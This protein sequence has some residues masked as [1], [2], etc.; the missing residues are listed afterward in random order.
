MYNESPVHAESCCGLTIKIFNDDCAVNPYEEWDRLGTLYHWHKR[1][2]IGESLSR[3]EGYE[4]KE[5]IKQIKQNGGVIVP[6]YLY[7]HGGQT[8]NTSGF[9]CPWD[10]G[11]VGFWAVTREEILKEYGKKRVSKAMREK[12]EAIIKSQVESIDDYLQG[13]VY[14]YVIE[15]DSGEELDSCWGFY[16]DYNTYCLGEAKSAAEF[17][18]KHILKEKQAKVKTWIKNRVPL[19]NRQALAA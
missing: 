14:G 8:I 18:F 1:D 13:K 19:E 17:C 4:I 12:V 9:S 10:S 5:K 15:N 11:Q 6:V 3:L 16:G 7:E 2:F